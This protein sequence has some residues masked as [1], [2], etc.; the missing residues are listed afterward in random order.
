[1]DGREEV[2][3]SLVVASKEIICS[4]SVGYA[5]ARQ[6]ALIVY[7]STA[8]ASNAFL[9]S[10]GC[11]PSNDGRLFE[12]NHHRGGRENTRAST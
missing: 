11:W 5:A 12:R 2:S 8:S 1:M 4:L 7:L 6:D 9:M 3:G 10:S